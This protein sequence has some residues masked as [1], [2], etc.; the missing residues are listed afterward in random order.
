MAGLRSLAPIVPPITIALAV[1]LGAAALL[2]A[3]VHLI[4]DAVRYAAIPTLD[5]PL[6]EGGAR[7]AVPGGRDCFFWGGARLRKPLSLRV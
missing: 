2:L 4:I 7:L 5:V 3:L 1:V 6:T